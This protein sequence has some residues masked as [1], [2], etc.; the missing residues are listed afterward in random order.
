MQKE[1][2]SAENEFSLDQ[3]KLFLHVPVSC[4]HSM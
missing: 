2:G 3:V 1:T 4:H